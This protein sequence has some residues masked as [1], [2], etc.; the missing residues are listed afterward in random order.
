MQKNGIGKHVSPQ[1]ESKTKTERTEKQYA[2]TLK[3]SPGIWIIFNRNADY[4]P[5]P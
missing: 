1:A 2:R 3:Q 4:K 5:A